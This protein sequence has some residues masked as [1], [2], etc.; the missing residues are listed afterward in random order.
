[1]SNTVRLLSLHAAVQEMVADGRLSA[2]HARALLPLPA[3]HQERLANVIEAQ[4][5]SVRRVEQLVQQT[6]HPGIPS[7]IEGHSPAPLSID[8]SALLRGLEEALGTPVTLQRRRRGGGRLTI[9]FYSDEELDGLYN[10]LG[11]PQL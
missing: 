7:R 5:L 9:D 2:G 1:V 3:E 11:G 4:G 8:D 10:R 6:T